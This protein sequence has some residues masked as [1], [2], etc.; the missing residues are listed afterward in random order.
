MDSP[1][2]TAVQPAPA[3]GA[4]G[5]ARLLKICVAVAA[6]LLVVPWA[7]TRGWRWY[8]T[9]QFRELCTAAHEVEDWHSQRDAAKRWAAWD[10]K[11]GRAWWYAAEAAQEL[12]DLDDLALCL[13]NVPPNDPKVLFALVEKA[14]LEWTVL[15]RPVEAL[16]TSRQAVARDPRVVEIQSRLISF[17][18][19]NLQRAPMLQAIR[20]AIDAGSEPRESYAYLLLAD[21]LSF[22]NGTD[23]NSRWLAAAPDELRFKIG[24]AVHT[25]MGIA[26]TAESAGSEEANELDRQ[27]MQQIKWFLDSAPHDAVLLTYVMYR[28]YQAG[29]VDR[30]GE[31]LK[32]V[33]E[34]SIDDHMIW[35]YRTWY[36]V[37]HDEFPQAEE[38]VREALRLHPLSPLAHHEFANLLR[39]RQRPA[40]EVEE[41]QKLAAAGREL[42]TTLLR[43]QSA[44]DVSPELVDSIAQYAER[45]DDPQVAHA[46]RTRLELRQSESQPSG[47]HPTGPQP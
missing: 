40:E 6:L 4:R 21:L 25:S 24:L 18:A 1:A 41:R 5:R 19:M 35:V 17:Y 43:L 26:Q 7:G 32:Q 42:R 31:L 20:A 37:A 13:G 45:C 34:T 9:K 10:P 28:T 44:L 22:T 46:V 11:A 12:D 33:D 27:A 30:M 14:N 29:D 39:K 36:H 23:L 8:R 15:N 3:T 38:A 16:E 47:S 2:E